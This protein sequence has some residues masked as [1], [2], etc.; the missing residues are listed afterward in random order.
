MSEAAKKIIG[1]ILGI[2]AMALTF[3]SYQMNSKKSLLFVQT[4]A[5]AFMCA[6]YFFLGAYSGCALTAVS[7]VRNIVF[8]FQSQETNFHY[9]S[10]FGFGL[11]MIVAGAFFWQGYVSLIIIIAIAANTVFMS[12]GDPQLLRKS[13]LFTSTAVFVYNVFVFSIGGMANE[14]IAIISSIIGIVRFRKDK[15]SEATSKQS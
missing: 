6:S 12:F 1:Q 11:L 7:V 13:I 8:Y 4:F 10:G 3:L 2:I 15:G 5:T 9:Y 14:T